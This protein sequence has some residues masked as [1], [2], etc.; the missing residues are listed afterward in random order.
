MKLTMSYDVFLSHNHVDKEWTQKPRDWL[1]ETEYIGRSLRAWLDREILKGIV[2]TRRRL[3]EVSMSQSN[4][5]LIDWFEADGC[6]GS[7]AGLPGPIRG[8]TCL[9]ME[10]LS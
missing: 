7:E 10:V 9:H 3:C 6:K 5:E 8:D 4:S 2:V 1:V